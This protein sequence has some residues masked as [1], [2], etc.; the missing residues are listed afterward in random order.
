MKT[1]QT[2]R[3]IY[4][5]GAQSTGKTTLLNA[6]RIYFFKAGNPNEDAPQFIEE[7]ARIVFE[8]EGFKFATIDTQSDFDKYLGIQKRILKTQLE[9][10][11]GA[12]R[13]GKCFITDRSG[14]DC[15]VYT[16]KYV[17][18]EGADALSQTPEL[19]EL[20]A[21]MQEGRVIVCEPV[22]D[23]LKDD[24]TGFRPIPEDKEQWFAVHEEFCELLNDLG[25]EYEVLPSTMTH[26]EDRVAFV[27]STW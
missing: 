3:N 18:K 21:R 22:A 24:G 14:L 12:L 5:I 6:L 27:L 10:E 23:W 16:S 2:R 9:A 19:A 4:I 13:N 20:K 7:T 11:D 8:Q 26:H 17:G 25:W 1:Q 15:L